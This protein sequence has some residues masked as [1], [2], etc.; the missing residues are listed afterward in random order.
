MNPSPGLFAKLLPDKIILLG[1]GGPKF[2]VFWKISHPYSLVTETE[3]LHLCHL[4]EAKLSENERESYRFLI[5]PF[6]PWQQRL[7][8]LCE[9]KGVQH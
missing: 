9:V 2:S 7:T 8:A 1:I 6:S 4:V 5:N 3:Y